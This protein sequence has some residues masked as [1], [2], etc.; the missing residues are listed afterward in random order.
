MKIQGRRP[1]FTSPFADARNRLLRSALRP[2]RWFRPTTRFLLCFFAFAILST[3]LLA[4][5]RSALTSAEVYQE[6]DVVRA[7]VVS[8][9]DITVEDARESEARREAARRETPAVW[10]YDPTQIDSAVQTFSAL[11]ATLK[12]QTD[13]RGQSNSNNLNANAQHEPVWPGAGAD[14]QAIARAIAAHNFDAGAL[15]M[16]TH[17]MR[18][19]GGGYVFGARDAQEVGPQARVVN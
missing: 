19:A 16:L 14:R 4:R 17:E 10:N 12:Q 7:D 9:A 5:T 2:F 8:P 3:L 1:R 13:A 6:G 11:W 15:E 18:D